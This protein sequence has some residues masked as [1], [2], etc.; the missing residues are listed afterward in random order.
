MREAGVGGDVEG[1]RVYWQGGREGGGRESVRPW[2]DGWQHISPPVLLLRGVTNISGTS[3]V[4]QYLLTATFFGR[5]TLSIFRSFINVATK[6]ASLKD[7]KAR[8]CK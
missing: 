4:D 7:E 3:E 1:R 8:N 2:T 5:T 6:V